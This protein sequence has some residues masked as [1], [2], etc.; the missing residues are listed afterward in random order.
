MTLCTVINVGSLASSHFGASREWLM[1]TWWI[2]FVCM[3][4]FVIEMLVKIVLDW[5]K[6][7]FSG[8]SLFFCH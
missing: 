5:R 3:L 2:N 6:Y 8:E 7:F 4:L 1:V